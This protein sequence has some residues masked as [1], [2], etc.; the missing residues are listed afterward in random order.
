MHHKHKLHCADESDGSGNDASSDTNSSSDSSNGGYDD[1]AAS[2][3]GNTG[4][5]E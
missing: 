1:G 5:D 3:Q 4:S 2:E